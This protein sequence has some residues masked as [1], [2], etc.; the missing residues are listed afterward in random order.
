MKIEKR[1]LWMNL[2]NRRLYKVVAV[3]E[4]VT[5]NK[6]RKGVLYHLHEDPNQKLYFREVYEFLEKFQYEQVD[7]PEY[8]SKYLD[9]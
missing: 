8:K 4:D 3:I 7:R 1:Q 6:I 2:K 9:P 5:G